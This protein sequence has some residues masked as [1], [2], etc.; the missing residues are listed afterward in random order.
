MRI[1]FSTTSI[2]TRA[3]KRLENILEV[4]NSTAKAMTAFVLGY[5]D[6]HE[7]H[8]EVGQ[9]QASTLDEQC[10]AEGLVARRS[11]QTQRLEECLG[12]VGLAVQKS[13]PELVAEWQP[14]SAHPQVLAKT[15]QEINLPEEKALRDGLIKGLTALYSGVPDSH[16]EVVGNDVL[17]GLP[18]L[19]GKLVESVAML[20]QK[21]LESNKQPFKVL[22]REMLEILA[23]RGNPVA[24]YG[25][26]VSLSIG[27]GGLVNGKRAADLLAKIVDM[28]EASAEIKQLAKSAM[29][30]VYSLG[31]GRQQSKSKATALWEDAAVNKGDAVAAFNAGLAT[32]PNSPK[33]SNGHANPENSAHFYRIAAKQGYVPAASNLGILLHTHP[34]LVEHILEGF[35]WIELAA[36]K[37][38]EAAVHVYAQINSRLN[39]V[40]RNLG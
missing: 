7:L 35:E 38:D 24:I 13:A 21:L 31:I 6:W 4:K 33:T 14:S 1:N 18:Y 5:R 3:A 8:S 26:A 12:R 9:W 19:P 16:L 37:G 23:R 27:D 20:A 10:S 22:G 28:P 40:L 2:P 39:N 32:D 25:L 36:S 30:N 29:A 15:S 34:H 11:Y 17:Q